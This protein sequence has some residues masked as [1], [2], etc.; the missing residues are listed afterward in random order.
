MYSDGVGWTFVKKKKGKK[1][2]P[3]NPAAIKETTNISNHIKTMKFYGNK[4]H[5]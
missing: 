3:G 5:N 1:K 4:S 2:N